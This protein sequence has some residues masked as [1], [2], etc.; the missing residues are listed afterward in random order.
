MEKDAMTVTELPQVQLR[1]RLF[2]PARLRLYGWLSLA[3]QIAIVVTGG[4]V[5]LTA[6]GLGCPEW[7]MCTEESLISTPE[8]GLHGVIEFGNRLLTFVLLIVAIITFVAVVR[9][10]KQRR[11]L[12]LP[13]VGLGIGI[14]VQAVLGGITVWTGLNSYVVGLHFLVS[15]VLIAIASLLVW[16]IYRPVAL[17]IHPVARQLSLPLTL[18]GTLAIIFGVLVTGAGPHAGDAETPRNGLDLEIWQ[19]YH[20]YP[21]YVMTGLLLVALALQI[22]REGFVLSIPIKILA[23]G[24][25]VALLQAAL[26]VVQARTGVPEL[27]VGVHMLGAAVTC[28][29]LGFAH[30]SLRGKNQIPV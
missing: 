6:S 11:G 19:H 27:L 12:I 15:G 25:I 29:V 13:A 3:T 17:N 16:R 2:G 9:S 1:D 5:R 4:A 10:R 24:S 14:L 8:M 22:R 20:S 26:G 23:I 18:S 21:A 7:P 30:L 28:A